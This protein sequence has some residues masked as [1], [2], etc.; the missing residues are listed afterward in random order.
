MKQ[1]FRENKKTGI[2]ILVGQTVLEL[3]TKTTIISGNK[4]RFPSSYGAERVSREIRCW[5]ASS[6]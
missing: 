4:S 5:A 3:L 1:I 6:I 2:K